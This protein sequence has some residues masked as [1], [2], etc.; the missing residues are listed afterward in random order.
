MLPEEGYLRLVSLTPGPA[1]PA[2]LALPVLWRPT[3]AGLPPVA[4]GYRIPF[5]AV[6]QWKPTGYAPGERIPTSITLYQ[7]APQDS[8]SGYTVGAPNAAGVAGAIESR[9]KKTTIRANEPVTIQGV[10]YAYTA[11]STGRRGLVVYPYRNPA[12]LPD[13]KKMVQ[14]P[15][16]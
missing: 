6:I 1:Q 13:A 16:N 15:F 4:P 3:K 14:I 10:L 5:E 2:I 12:G 9:A 8:L 11:A 7:P